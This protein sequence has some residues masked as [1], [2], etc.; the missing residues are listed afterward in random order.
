MQKKKSSN[1]SKRSPLASVQYSYCSNPVPDELRVTL[2]YADPNDATASGGLYNYV[3][4][5]NDVYDPDVTGVGTQPAFYDELT[6]IYNRWV[7]TECEYDVAI[8]CR[9]AGGRLS[10]AVAPS[11]GFNPTTYLAAADMRYAKTGEATYGG[12]SVHI[13]GTIDNAKLF[14]VPGYA[15]ESDDALQ[16]STSAS[17]SRRLNL[18]ICCDTNGA[19]DVFTITTVLKY[20]VRFFQSRISSTSLF[21]PRQGPR[22]LKASPP[23]VAPCPSNQFETVTRGCSVNCLGACQAVSRP[24][25]GEDGPVFLGSCPRQ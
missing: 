18:C 22:R 5:T 20:K 21:V 15:Y 1:K 13:R 6:A 12:P 14:G 25:A 19:S 10:V 16:G 9:S 3:Y 17:P 23:S 4:T 2:R 24:R 7:V 11:T 8:T